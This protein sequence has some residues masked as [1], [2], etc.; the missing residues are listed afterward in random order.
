MYFSQIWS[1]WNCTSLRRTLCA[2]SKHHQRE[3]LCIPL[4]LVRHTCLYN[5]I[6]GRKGNVFLTLLKFWRQV[7]YR[8]ST[9]LLPNLR[10]MLLRARAKLNKNP[11]QVD[12][13]CRKFRLGDWFVLYQLGKNIDPLIFRE[14][15]NDLYEKLNSLDAEKND[16]KLY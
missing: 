1:V 9:C 2:S 12:A 7:T 15:I 5:G 16:G 10:T 13:I 6:P 4:V 8:L 14:F 11:R 3:N